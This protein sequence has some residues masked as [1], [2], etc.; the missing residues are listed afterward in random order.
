MENILCQRIEQPILL[1]L[2][3]QVLNVTTLKVERNN[4][5]DVTNEI[6]GPGYY[7][8][9]TIFNM[10]NGFNFNSRVKT[11]QCY[12]FGKKPTKKIQPAKSI[13]NL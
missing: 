8:R 3:D 2:E 10:K 11:N 7:K 4:Y 13:G 5:L 12:S 1:T 9:E 6:P